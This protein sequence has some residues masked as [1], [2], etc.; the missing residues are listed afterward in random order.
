MLNNN[1]LYK[2]VIP[3]WCKTKA[4]TNAEYLQN[5]KRYMSTSYPDRKILRIAN[6]FVEC[7][8]KF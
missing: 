8:R 1:V 2:V 5:I 3:D 6:G 4:S 7:E